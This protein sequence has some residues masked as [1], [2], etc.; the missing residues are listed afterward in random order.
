MGVVAYKNQQ[1]RY[2]CS[3][4]TRDID[5]GVVCS[6]VNKHRIHFKSADQAREASGARAFYYVVSSTSGPERRSTK[7][8]GVYLLKV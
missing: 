7:P 2:A 4:F 6:L 3:T 5:D 8:L 1:A